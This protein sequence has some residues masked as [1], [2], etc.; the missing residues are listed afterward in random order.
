MIDEFGAFNP[1]DEVGSESAED[2]T[3]KK[4]VEKESVE[5][6]PAPEVSFE[7]THHQEVEHE[8]EGRLGEIEDEYKEL[9]EEILDIDEGE[10]T[11]WLIQR[12]GMGI[13]KIAGVV[14]VIIFLMWSIWGGNGD[15]TTKETP[16][17]DK[18]IEKIKKEAVKKETEKS[19]KKSSKAESSTEKGEGFWS[20]IFGGNEKT[21]STKDSVKEEVE[22]PAVSEKEEKELA[23][24]VKSSS[25]HV[26]TIQ[27]M[28]WNYWL[29][30][31]R[32]LGKKNSPGEAALWTKD[33][34]AIFDIPFAK[35]VEGN[36]DTE[37]ERRVNTL[38]SSVTEALKK[39]EN[40][41]NKLQT[42]EA[43]FDVK[44]KSYIAKAVEYERLFLEAMDKSDPVGIDQFLAKK[45]EAEKDQ[46]E[47]GIEKESRQFLFEK[48]DSY[49]QVLI[50]LREYL[51]AN[52]KA[53]VKDVQVVAFPEDPF[54][55]IIPLETW[56]SL[57][58]P[59]N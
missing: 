13:L 23:V 19:A 11:M 10:D 15:N 42:E 54:N 22:I 47:N 32:L 17:V 25:P 50:N 31:D 24:E 38:M 36:S 55:R 51:L 27:I 34:E 3:E 21:S 14:G 2:K 59:I 52:K 53:L 30:K 56:E 57:K 18:K 33:A 37:R 39:A 16:S 49:A 45:I 8:D 1:F 9:D 7:E 43:E 44:E 41:Q 26:A 48:I 5:E 4:S 35:Q 46:I 12:M 6:K 40:I 28:A 58:Y 20:K 29:E